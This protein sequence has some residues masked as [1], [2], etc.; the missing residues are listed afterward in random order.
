MKRLLFSMMALAVF[1]ASAQGALT[2]LPDSE[3][4]EYN[5]YSYFNENGVSGRLEFAVYDTTIQELGELGGMSGYNGEQYVYAYQIFSMS[6]EA[7]TAFT[8]TGYSADA[9]TEADMD[10]S[11]TLGGGESYGH[12]T[13]NYGLFD[14]EA[15][16]FFEGGVLVAYETS[17][18]LMIFSDYAPV[19]GGYE[20]NPSGSDPYV[21]GGEGVDSVPEPMTLILLASGALLT[22]RRK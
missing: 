6:A 4:P 19:V 21:P 16:W 2:L 11:D 7:I 10:T 9:F 5:G 1:T 3:M 12:D 22:L 20:V 13:Q 8:L 18:F 14:D 17:Y 15:V